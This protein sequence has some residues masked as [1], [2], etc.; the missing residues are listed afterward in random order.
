MLPKAALTTSFHTT[1]PTPC[2]AQQGPPA[3]C[4]PLVQA[5]SCFAFRSAEVRFRVRSFRRHRSASVSINR[6]LSQRP[7]RSQA[8]PAPRLPPIAE[9]TRLPCKPEPK[10]PITT[11]DEPSRPAKVDSILPRLGGL[12]TARC[13][14]IRRVCH[15][16]K[17]RVPLRTGPGVSAEGQ[18]TTISLSACNASIFFSAQI[19]GG[20]RW[21]NNHNIAYACTCAEI[22]HRIISWLHKRLD[23]TKN[24]RR[25]LLCIR[26]HQEQATIDQ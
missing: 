5:D 12:A 19:G 9:A 26:L 10:R 13:R 7:N 15:L 3:R 25:C 16:V 1:L 17:E 11:L 4:D 22:R 14:A 24:A 18:G 21:K 20:L 2:Y 6:V 23:A 8:V